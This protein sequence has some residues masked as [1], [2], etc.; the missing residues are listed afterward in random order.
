MDEINC[1]PKEG[2]AGACLHQVRV[3]NQAL[4]PKIQRVTIT[5]A[6]TQKTVSCGAKIWRLQVQAEATSGVTLRLAFAAGEVTNGG[7]G[8]YWTI[9]QDQVFKADVHR[10]SGR[11][12]LATVTGLTN[13]IVNVLSWQ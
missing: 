5:S 11:F 3:E 12:Y 6:N 8:N 4:I 9:N 10:H 13:T 7:A 2:L 1:V